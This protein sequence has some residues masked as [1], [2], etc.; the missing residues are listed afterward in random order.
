MG[1][2]R[3]VRPRI[4]ERSLLRGRTDIW[5]GGAPDGRAI[6][7]GGREGGTY[8]VP[9]EAVRFLAWL[10]RRPSGATFIEAAKAYPGMPIDRLV[11][12]GLV[13]AISEATEPIE[14][15]AVAKWWWANVRWRARLAFRGWPEFARLL[16]VEN[17]Q[18]KP[19]TPR[20]AGFDG[21]E[22]ASRVALGLPFTSR[23]CTVVA[24]AM[25]DVLRRGGHEA[26][27]QLCVTADQILMHARAVAQ[28]HI[29]EPDPT[30]VDVAAAVPITSIKER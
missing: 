24:A 8:R 19:S 30:R 27:I 18:P 12:W 7:L 25:V 11:A 26:A 23:Q 29:I 16:Q 28:G 6:V 4:A 14:W 15:R 22:A 10:C 5:V 9:A 1:R 20:P 2:K 17:L 3:K 13:D 21:L